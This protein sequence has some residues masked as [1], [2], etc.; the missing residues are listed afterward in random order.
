[1]L[2]FPSHFFWHTHHTSRKVWSHSYEI[3]MQI[4]CGIP[5]TTLQNCVCTNINKTVRNITRVCRGR[6]SHL[7]RS[8]PLRKA[9]GW[10]KP[11]GFYSSQKACMSWH[12]CSNSPLPSPDLLANFL[13]HCLSL[14]SQKW[15]CTGQN[16][17]LQSSKCVATKPPALAPGT[18]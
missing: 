4:W 18:Q 5:L 8:P 11:G 9:K 15:G 10:G 17:G 6:F 3:Y 7:A 2:R 1:M 13:Y 12:Y 14:Q 16:I